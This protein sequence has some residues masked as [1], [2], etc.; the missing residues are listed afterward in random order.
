MSYCTQCGAVIQDTHRCC[1]KCGTYADT[2]AVMRSDLGFRRVTGP[3]IAAAI[4]TTVWCSAS[5]AALILM[6]AITAS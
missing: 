4:D 6:C 3:R 2:L 1:G 5:A